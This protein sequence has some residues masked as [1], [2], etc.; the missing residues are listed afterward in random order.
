MTFFDEGAPA[1]VAIADRLK[2]GDK[3]SHTRPLRDW[4]PQRPVDYHPVCRLGSPRGNVVAASPIPDDLLYKYRAVLSKAWSSGTIH[5]NFAFARI[6][7]KPASRGQC[8]VTSA[9]L[10]HK[11]RQWQP[12]IRA[13]YCYG[14]IVSLDQ[15]FGDHCWVEIKGAASPERWVID[16]TC[17]QFDVFK[18]EAVRCESYASLRRRSIEYQVISQLSYADLKRDLVWKRFKK[19]KYRIRLS[20]PLASVR[21]RFAAATRSS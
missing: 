4:L 5:P 17:D 7:G 11:L 3:S 1:S 15:T 10:L 19:L 20:S 8:G 2:V 18:G 16:L 21:L 6:D 13:T 9:W 14:D 12:E